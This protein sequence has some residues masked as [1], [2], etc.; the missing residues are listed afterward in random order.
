MIVPDEKNKVLADSLRRWATGVGD[1]ARWLVNDPVGFLGSA[2]QDV[3][4]SPEQ[5]HKGFVDWRIGNYQ[6]AEA[7]KLM[8]LGMFSLTAQK[9]Q[10]LAKALNRDKLSL[11]R[12]QT[13]SPQPDD[14]RFFAP[15][16]EIAEQ[17]V[18]T[19]AHKVSKFGV[20]PDKII[21]TRQDGLGKYLRALAN[22]TIKLAKGF[23]DDIAQSDMNYAKQL[24][25]LADDLERG[26]I[27]PYQAINTD[28]FRSL[29]PSRSGLWFSGDWPGGESMNTYDTFV[30]IYPDATQIL[31]K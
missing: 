10:R 9:P 25:G 24:L 13:P 31:A 15:T 5:A 4:P 26:L 1:R 11:W 27:A 29:A 17:Y 21:D 22:E 23:D 2:V 16:R 6:S 7:Q 18:R 30:M 19:P 8:N 3:V 12:A 20:S 28:A 14:L